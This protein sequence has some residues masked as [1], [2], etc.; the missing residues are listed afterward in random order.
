MNDTT[1]EVSA[2]FNE[3]N[4]GNA[5][6][7]EAMTTLQKG[8]REISVSIDEISGSIIQVNEGAQNVSKMAE[9]NQTAIGSIS[10][11]VDEFEV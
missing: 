5:L 9:N 6:M 3:M 1:A 4:Q 8:S 7:L 11:V 2:G 10:A